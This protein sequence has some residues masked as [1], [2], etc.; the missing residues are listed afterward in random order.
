LA[1]G[2]NIGG[3][4]G[5]DFGPRQ[6]CHVSWGPETHIINSRSPEYNATQGPNSQ[7]G[8]ST[9]TNQPNKLYYKTQVDAK[10]R[11]NNMNEIGIL[12][13]KVCFVTCASGQTTEPDPPDQCCFFALGI[14][15]SLK[16]KPPDVPLFSFYFCLFCVSGVTT[17]PSSFPRGDEGRGIIFSEPAMFPHLLQMLSFLGVKNNMPANQGFVALC[18]WN[19][20]STKGIHRATYGDCVVYTAMAIGNCSKKNKANEPVQSRKDPSVYSSTTYSSS[21][22]HVFIALLVCGRPC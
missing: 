3:P 1:P 6:P 2:P 20:R 12:D 22:S 9:G 18:S 14:L 7:H 17:T 10:D 4:C 8:G 19:T 15:L 21:K 5:P 13:F 16:K 11:P